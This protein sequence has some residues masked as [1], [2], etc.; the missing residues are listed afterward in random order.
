MRKGICSVFVFVLLS[1]PSAT[2][3][4]PPEIQ[5]DRYL[6]AARQAIE[7]QN[8]T[9]AQ[10]ALDKMSLL[11]TEKDLEL[12]EEF[13]FRSAQVAQQSRRPARAIQMVTRYLELAGRDGEHYIAA[14]E[15]LSA[16]EAETF[17]AAQTCQ[18][19]AKGSE[20]WKELANQPGCYVW[21]EYLLPDQTVTWTG[22]CA[23]SLAQ[24]TGSLKWVSDGGKNATES[25]GRL[26]SGKHHGRWKIRYS[27][28]H[29]H[30]GPYEQGKRHGKWVIQWADDNG[31]VSGNKTEGSYVE[32]K[33]Q[34]LWT[35]R[36]TDGSIEKWPYVDGKRHGRLTGLDAD[37]NTW[38]VSYV[39]G[40]K[41]GQYTQRTAAGNVKMEG[42]FV[43]GQKHGAWTEEAWKGIYVE[44]K[45]HGRWVRRDDDGD[46][47]EEGSYLEGK[48]HGDWVDYTFDGT[49][50]KR[51]PYVDGVKHG[52]WVEFHEFGQHKGD[53]VGYE[54]EGPYVEGK[55]HGNWVVYLRGNK[56]GRILGGGP[57]VDGVKHG[58]WVEHEDGGRITEG[59]YVE[60]KRDGTWLLY[61]E[62]KKDNSSTSTLIYA[63]GSILPVPLEP[64][65]VVIPAG[66]YRRGCR[67]DCEGIWPSLSSALPVQKVKV[68]SFELSKYEVTFEEYDRFTA[69]TD[70][71]PAYDQGW[72]RG[73]R[74]VIN[75]SRKD[76]VAYTKWLSKKTGAR[77]RLPS[78]A[79]WEYAAR[80]G[81]K[82]KKY[83]W[84]NEIGHNRANCSNC[85]SQWKGRQT[86][87][88]GSFGPNA[89]GL[90]D[91]HGNVWEWVQ[92]CWNESY[93]GAPTN[94][95][96]WESGDCSQRVFRG[97]SWGDTPRFVRSAYRDRVLGEGGNAAG[98]RV[99]RTIIP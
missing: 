70:R 74:P 69:A 22:E 14:L 93:Q 94:G 21:D 31:N 1:G 88:V 26:E 4:L 54:R 97:G 9:A 76:I 38:E 73:R 11:E 5:A 46:I 37:G 35:A 64:L 3:Q 99:A 96:A 19:K 51:G 45:K 95:S 66:E 7:R 50:W 61:S 67:S 10:T 2:A 89:W 48:R 41:N 32:G 20:C 90:Y 13:H 30:E 15:L 62:G 78:E 72:G 82:K 80:S 68:E 28:G 59:S 56:K 77:Y 49:I 47:D 40:K 44:G 29:V 85:D 58:L 42:P 34:G 83:S 81:S 17:N 92:D 53:P 65:M 84:G 36:W 63:N 60:G 87:P 79:E 33:F 23:E 18:G 91:M 75:V 8:F 43:E 71:E 12:P 86:A 39:E 16:A 25:S 57:Y 55:K 24:G 98:F 27:N 6:L 52:R